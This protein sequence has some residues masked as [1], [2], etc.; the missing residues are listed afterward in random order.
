MYYELRRLRSAQKRGTLVLKT[1]Y[2]KRI[3]SII[4]GIWQSVCAKAVKQAS[5]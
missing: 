3:G 1:T 2:D 4:R 5:S